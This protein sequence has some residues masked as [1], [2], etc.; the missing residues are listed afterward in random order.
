MRYISE[1]LNQFIATTRTRFLKWRSYLLSRWW[2]ISNFAEHLTKKILFMHPSKAIF[3]KDL[4]CDSNYSFK[5]RINECF[6]AKSENNFHL[7]L[8]ECYHVRQEKFASHVSPRQRCKVE[9]NLDQKQ[10]CNRDTFTT[11]DAVKTSRAWNRGIFLPTFLSA[12]KQWWYRERQKH[13]RPCIRWIN[14]STSVK[15]IK[16]PKK[17]F[18]RKIWKKFTLSFAATI[19]KI[20]SN[21]PQNL[22]ILVVR[23]CHQ[24]LESHI[25]H[26]D[27]PS[28]CVEE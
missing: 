13:P 17:F 2:F 25:T 14:Y 5:Q 18:L 8:P 1:Q 10:I 7:I 15:G 24:L 22:A 20:Y 19:A 6:E 16:M 27:S 12:M 21:F 23:S 9:K 3:E 11:S 26:N 28:L 4:T